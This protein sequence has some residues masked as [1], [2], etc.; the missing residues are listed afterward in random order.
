LGQN[1]E[2]AFS[3]L[4]VATA[5][6]ADL[7][8]LY[9]HHVQRV[10]TWAR[11]LG[12]PTIDVEDTVQEVFLIA[13][14]SYADFEPRA[15]ITT[16]LFRI[17]SNVVR[18]QWRRRH[19]RR[20]LSPEAEVPSPLEGPVE[21]LAQ[22]EAEAR[23]YLALEYV[24]PRYREALILFELDEKSGEEIAELLGIKVASVWTRLHRG[25]KELLSALRRIEAR[26]AHGQSRKESTR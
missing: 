21:R 23:L 20:L 6:A 3:G 22:A 16:W 10:S 18:H 15:K 25:R 5:T 11:R 2:I 24:R 1:S 9:R 14:R 26:E 19:W 17:T 4:A 8:G 13:C 7:E 12:G